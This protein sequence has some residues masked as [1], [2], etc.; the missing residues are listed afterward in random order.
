[1]SYRKYGN[2]K[3]TV[4]GMIFDSKREAN[5]YRELKLYQEKGLITNLKLQPKFLLQDKFKYEGKTERAITYIAD[6]SYFDVK[7]GKHIVEDVK[8]VETE[9]FKIKRKLFLNL[10]GMEYTFKTIKY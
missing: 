3:I 10:Y 9:V 4:D 8:G 7:K 1:M 6:F 5:R 2:K